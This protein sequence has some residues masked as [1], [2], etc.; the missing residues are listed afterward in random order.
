M[1]LRNELKQEIYK[2]NLDEL[3]QLITN[4]NVIDIKKIKEIVQKQDELNEEYDFSS[5][6]ARDR[7]RV[8]Q[9]IH[10]RFSYQSHTPS[11]QLREKNNQTYCDVVMS[12]L[13]NRDNC[14]KT[15]E[16]LEHLERGCLFF[17]TSDYSIGSYKKMKSILLEKFLEIKEREDISIFNQDDLNKEMLIESKH[18]VNETYEEL[19]EI[20]DK[21]DARGIEL[22]QSELDKALKVA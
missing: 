2:F 11:K 21:A 14:P 4:S 17:E 19:N 15:K 12:Y 5:R 7:H 16:D 18:L 3:I 13:L 22:I 6:Y 9:L 8:A 20:L 1:I 10:N